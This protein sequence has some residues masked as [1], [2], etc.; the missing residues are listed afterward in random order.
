MERLSKDYQ[1]DVA[2]SAGRVLERVSEKGDN[3]V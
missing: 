1:K 3:R 2:A